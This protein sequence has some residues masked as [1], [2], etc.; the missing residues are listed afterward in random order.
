MCTT[1][2][3]LEFQALQHFTFLRVACRNFVVNV[4]SLFSCFELLVT[5]L[6]YRVNILSETTGA[7]LISVKTDDGRQLSRNACIASVPQDVHDDVRI[8]LKSLSHHDVQTI[9]CAT[10]MPIVYG[11]FT[12]TILIANVG[13]FQ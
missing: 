11:V 13:S 2:K 4:A 9:E 6:C 3:T 10:L 8:L 1:Q 7:V 12:L 5:L